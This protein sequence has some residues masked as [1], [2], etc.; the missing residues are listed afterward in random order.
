MEGKVVLIAGVI[1]AT[2]QMHYWKDMEENPIFVG[3]Y[4]IVENRDEYDLIKV[5]G[6]IFTTKKDV[7]KFSNTTYENMKNVICT[8]DWCK[9]NEFMDKNIREKLKEKMK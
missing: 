7:G 9:L 6:K 5:V 3:D 2:G 4:A 1:N 8:V